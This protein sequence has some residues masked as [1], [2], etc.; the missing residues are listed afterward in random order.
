MTD[1][2]TDLPPDF[3]RPTVKHVEGS[4]IGIR[5][6]R[7]HVKPVYPLKV[8]G[9][10]VL[11]VGVLATA[12]SP[13][14]GPPEPVCIAQ[15]SIWKQGIEFRHAVCPPGVDVEVSPIPA[16]GFAGAP[17]PLAYFVAIH[18]FSPDRIDADPA[19]WRLLWTEKKGVQREDPSLTDR[20]VGISRLKQSFG[21][22]TL[23]TDQSASGFV[24]F[25]KPKAKD[26]AIVIV[27]SPDQD[28]A[29]TVQ[30]AVS[31]IPA[32]LLP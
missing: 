26:A 9:L 17:T 19:Q 1:I 13:P 6:F 2:Q 30:I 18:N 5:T 27:F 15:Q 10:L 3:Q 4:E 11:T 28:R 20:Q 16:P 25:K 21:R 22:S 24:Y 14:P 23:F 32:A 12:Q 8:R 31:G 29:V 7:A